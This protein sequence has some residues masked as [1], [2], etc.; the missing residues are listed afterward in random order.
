MLPSKF[1]WKG[2]GSVSTLSHQLVKK[3]IYIV[4]NDFVGFLQ[5]RIVAKA[6]W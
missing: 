4:Y 6:A 2:M 3:L 5:A 1:I